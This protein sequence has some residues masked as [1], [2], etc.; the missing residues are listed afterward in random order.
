MIGMIEGIQIKPLKEIPDERGVFMELLRKDWKDL[1]EEHE[2]IQANLSVSYPGIIRGWHRHLRGQIDYFL[3]LKGA[4][5]ICAY[6]EDSG[7]LDEVISTEYNHQIVKIPGIYWHG[8]KVINDKPAWLLYFVN[9]LY[10]YEKPDEIHR[11][12]NDPTIVPK[13]I[14]GKTNDPRV[15]KPWDWFLPPHK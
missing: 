11:S 4:L 5:K 13:S 15:G 2:I 8:F 10:D 3:V 6:D 7:E 9:K 12:W 14:N 1:L